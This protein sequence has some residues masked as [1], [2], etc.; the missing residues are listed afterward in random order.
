MSSVQEIGKKAFGFNQNIAKV[1]LNDNLTILEDSVFYNC[2]ALTD[3]NF[4]TKLISIGDNSF[5]SGDF[6]P[7]FFALKRLWNFKL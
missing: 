1:V 4:P 2:R 7:Y 3:I 6:P 5:Y